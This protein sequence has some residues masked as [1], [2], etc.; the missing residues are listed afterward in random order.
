MLQEG[1]FLQTLTKR[2][3]SGKRL[4][5]TRR[6]AAPDPLD[7]VEAARVARLHYVTDAM[8]GI[9][10]KRVGKRFSYVG[11]DGKPIHDESH[12]HRIRALAIPPAWRDVWICPLPTG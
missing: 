1:A 2:L 12:L 4:A 6:E 5:R 11:M 9:R 8:P 7:P 10:R 3:Q